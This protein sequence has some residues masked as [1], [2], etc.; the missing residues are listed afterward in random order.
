LSGKPKAGEIVLNKMSVSATENA[1]M[2]TIFSK[3]ITNIHVAAAEPEI[4]ELAHYLNSMGAKIKGAGTHDITIEGVSKL[5]G[6]SHAI[7][8]D[9]VEVGTYLIAA[10]ATNSEVKIGP[11]ISSHISI[12][13]KKLKDAGAN[14][15]IINENNKEYIQT[16]KHG[17]LKSMSIDTRTYPGFP[18]DLQSPY[19]ILMTQAK[20][21]CQIFETLFEGRF[22]YLDEIKLMGHALKF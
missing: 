6:T 2:A 22:L 18:T 7:V 19:A 14:I 11:I 12:V 21:E 16:K 15:S 5:N 4:I 8:P 3:G 17:E 1:I 20:G 10:I 13:L 9:R